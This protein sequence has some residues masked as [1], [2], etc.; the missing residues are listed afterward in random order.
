MMVDSFEG[1]IIRKY[2]IQQLIGT[3]SISHIY[4]AQDLES[5]RMVAVKV[6]LESAAEEP[7]DIRR[8]QMEAVIVFRLDHPNIVPLYDYWR[9]AT[10]VWI[11]TPWMPGGSLRDQFLS[12]GW[13]LERTAR[14][15]Q[16]I[17]AALHAAHTINIIHRDIKPDNILF[18]VDGNAFLA[19]FGAAKRLKS[20]S[21]THPTVFV[22]SPAYLSPE[23]IQKGNLTPCTDIYAL[24]VTLHETLAGQ[25]PF[26]DATTKMK[27]ILK[28]LNEPLPPLE[29]LRPDLPFEVAEVIAIATA[30]D[31][32]QRYPDMMALAE[33]FLEAAKL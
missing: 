9:D 29:Q 8:M 24:G 19:D 7:D 16:Q 18:D 5:G 2:Q 4:K 17:T 26:L 32:E 28:H 30:K 31:P 6:L 12:G 27:M 13:S 10:G 11:V 14:M 21:I 15:V 3:G 22:G 1:S 20:E 23:Q 33:A 25:H